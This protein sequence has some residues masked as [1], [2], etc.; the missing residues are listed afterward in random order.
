MLLSWRVESRTISEN[1]KDTVKP[2]NPVGEAKEKEVRTG[3][4]R[5]IVKA[6]TCIALSTG[7]LVIIC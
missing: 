7:I 3:S 6:R 4:V 5:S 1:C 2:T